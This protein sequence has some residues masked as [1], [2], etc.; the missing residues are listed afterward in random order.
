MDTKERLVVANGSKSIERA[1]NNGKW[2]TYKVEDKGNLKNGVY[3]LH[4]ARAIKSNN[5]G[6]FAGTIIH[7]DKNNVYQDQGEKGIA[8]FDRQAFTQQPEIGR[9]TFINY[10][11]GR[12]T[13]NDGRTVP[14]AAAALAALDKKAEAD[15]LTPAQRAIVAARVRQNVANS[16]ERGNM[17][18]VK[19]KEEIQVKQ[20]HKSERE[21]SR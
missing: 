3:P 20:E 10:E 12:A 7:A 1:D 8:R 9:S 11:Y 6:E 15:G 4:E 5:K 17:P 13:I 21:Q 14:A 19:I 16:I 18:E 2:V